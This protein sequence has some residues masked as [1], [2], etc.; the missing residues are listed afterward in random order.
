MDLT[1]EELLKAAET[2]S[3]YCD[4]HIGNI[5]T[6]CNDD[7]WFIE[8]CNEFLQ[9]DTINTIMRHFIDNVRHTND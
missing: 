4:D 2:L 7:C 5:C 8:T 3:K 1:K 6:A 9:Y